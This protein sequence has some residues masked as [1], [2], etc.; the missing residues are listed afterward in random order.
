MAQ[1][2]PFRTA[3]LVFPILLIAVGGIFLYANWY[4]AFDPLPILWKYWPLALIF[5]G[6]GKMWDS[7]RRRQH[8]GTPP[9]AS[10][11]ATVGACAF[12][13]VLVAL[14]WNGRYY[15]RH[16]PDSVYAMQHLSRTVDRDDAK[17][18]RLS[19]EMGAGD[20]NL[21]GGASHLLEADF[22][23][24]T[25][26][27]TPKVDYSISGTTG[28]LR[29]YQGDSDVHINT[30]SDNHWTLHL[31]NDVPL[32]IKMEMGAGRGNLRLRDIDVR[33]LTLEVGAGQADVD[34]TG[35][36]KSDLTADL[37]G[38]VGEANI[39][40]PKNVGVIVHASGGIGT[41]DA[42]GLHHDGDEYTNDAYGK[43]PATIHLKVSGGVGRI[44]LMQEP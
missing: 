30:T 14:L 44:T 24:R 22:D 31:A 32:E 2:R 35:D 37:E 3:S 27:G 9:G 40:L 10:M 15:A 21:S 23:Y 17:D 20:I 16:H 25:S 43:A 7:W 41:I 36:R 19:L 12:V 1:D 13:V 29:V 38:G 34:L 18:V 8:P 4:P 28:N 11:G 39:R 5:L 6:L 26:S 42:R 33:R